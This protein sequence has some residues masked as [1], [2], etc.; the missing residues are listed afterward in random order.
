MRKFLSIRVSLGISITLQGRPHARSSWLT[1]NKL[2]G[3]CFFVCGL[4]N[5][6][7]HFCFIFLTIAH[8]FL[9]FVVLFSFHF[10]VSSFLKGRENENMKLRILEVRV[11]LRHWR[12]DQNVLY[13]F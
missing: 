10:V 3:V 5:S 9:F 6:C 7:W 12:Q 4:L 1:H 2:H 13:V 11:S 8:S